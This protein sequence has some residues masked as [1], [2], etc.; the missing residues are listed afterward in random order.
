MKIIIPVAAAIFIVAVPMEAFAKEAGRPVGNST[1]AHLLSQCYAE[2]DSYD[3]PGFGCCSPTL[4]YCIECS[5]DKS[6]KCRKVSIRIAPPRGTTTQ[7][8][9]QFG[10]KKT[11]NAGAISPRS[12]WSKRVKKFRFKTR[13]VAN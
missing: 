3:S 10:A 7:A 8:P 9:S 13:R 2:D 6:E 1:A 5:S 12:P 11:S 4:G